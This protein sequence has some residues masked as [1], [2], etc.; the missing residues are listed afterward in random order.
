MY[1]NAD[2]WN[3]VRGSGVGINVSGGAPVGVYGGYSQAVNTIESSCGV[4]KPITSLVTNNDGVP[5]GTM[6]YGIT[7]P[8]LNV[9]GSYTCTG[10]H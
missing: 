4:G 7:S 10:V 5:V 8:N 1:S 9:S 3:Q 2:D 6:E